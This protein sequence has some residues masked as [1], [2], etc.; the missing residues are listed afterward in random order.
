[1]YRQLG[2]VMVCALFGGLAAGANEINVWEGESESYYF[3][4]DD[5]VV[6]TQP[7]TFKMEALD[8][9]GGLGYIAAITVDFQGGHA[10][11]VTVYVVRD[12]TEVPGGDPH[13][14]G[15]AEVWQIDLSPATVGTVAELRTTGNYGHAT[16]GAALHASSAG[17]IQIGTGATTG[18]VINP[19]DI[20]GAIT[21]PVQITGQ[22][23]A[24]FA[25][26]SAQDI[27]IAYGGEA[28]IQI[29]RTCASGPYRGTLHFDQS[30]STNVTLCGLTGT[31]R[32]ETPGTLGTLVVRDI[33]E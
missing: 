20:T 24:D 33:A 15:A 26:E 27:T 13:Q 32:V 25:C 19:I 17:T 7:G 21:G 28:S 8:G 23:L 16:E 2:L 1:M 12:P 30:A 22:L 11:P 10:G 4:G 5:G 18:D 9:S 3:V 31:G 6:I 29:G 14:P